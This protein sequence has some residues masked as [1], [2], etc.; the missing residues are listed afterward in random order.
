MIRTCPIREAVLGSDPKDCNDTVHGLIVAER[1][2]HLLMDPE[3]WAA[4]MPDRSFSGK[5]PPHWFPGPYSAYTQVMKLVSGGIKKCRCALVQE[6]VRYW[7]ESDSQVDVQVARDE[8]AI[9]EVCEHVSE[10]AR[11]IKS[12]V[13]RALDER[14]G[15]SLGADPDVAIARLQAQ[16][17]ACKAIKA[18][19][20]EDKKKKEKEEKEQRAAKRQRR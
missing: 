2:R 10:E 19:N 14:L 4:L 17:V 18:G 1:A 11:G 5:Q 8:A 3:V 13:D 16:I 12:H 20:R 9:G 7:T 15:S 6:Y